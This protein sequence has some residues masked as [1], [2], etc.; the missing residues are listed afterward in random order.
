[1]RLKGITM[2]YLFSFSFAVL[3]IALFINL[4]EINPYQQEDA[5]MLEQI[6]AQ[7]RTSVSES[8]VWE[9]LELAA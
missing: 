2:L 5:T 3:V 4:S 7:M 1:V 8:E 6:E 9:S